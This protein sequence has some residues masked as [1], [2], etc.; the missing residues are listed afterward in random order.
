LLILA[1]DPGGPRDGNVYISLTALARRANVPLQDAEQAVEQLSQ[2]E[3]A[4]RIKDHEGRRLEFIDGGYKLFNFKRYAISAVRSA[5]GSSGGRPP[6]TE[7][8]PKQTEAY[9]T[10]GTNEKE[11]ETKPNETEN[12]RTA[13]QSFY[14]PAPRSPDVSRNT[15]GLHDAA[16]AN[17][18]V[19]PGQRPKLEAE[20][21]AL[22]RAISEL[23][24]KDPA[25]VLALGKRYR[26]GAPTGS[27]NP[28]TFTDDRLLN[29]VLD[30]RKLAKQAQARRDR[31]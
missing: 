16:P 31:G 13:D 17:P 20:C 7:S 5:A 26:E 15:D 28:A 3:P 24:G 30:L 2:P 1:S 8:N 22:V 6:T 27:L 14:R 4:S 19:G 9:E 10:K 12:E 23:T 29:T 21:L 18:L 11:K 25:E